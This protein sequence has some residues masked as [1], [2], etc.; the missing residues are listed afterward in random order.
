L[1]TCAKARTISTTIAAAETLRLKVLSKVASERVAI[2]MQSAMVETGESVLKFTTVKKNNL[3][4]TPIPRAALELALAER[5]RASDQQCE[6]FLKVFVERVVATSPGGAN[7]AVKGVKY[8][9]AVRD[10][11]NV[12]IIRYVEESQLEFEISD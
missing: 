2:P 9:K 12:A 5:I 8:G 3:K 4:R 1:R 10:K 11:C 7:W 6:G